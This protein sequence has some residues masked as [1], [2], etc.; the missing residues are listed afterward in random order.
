MKTSN[1][2]KIGMIGVG[3]F[4]GY[5]RGTLRQAGVFQL[6]AAYDR[7]AT[8][9]ET[10]RTEDGARSVESVEALLAIPEIEGIVISTGVDTHA[11]LTIKALDAGKHVLVEKP[12]CGRIEEIQPILDARNKARRVVAMGH[13]H[14]G[15]D[16][17]NQLIQRLLS[18]GS[19][20]TLTCYEENTSHSGGLEIKPGDWRGLR[21]RNPGGMLLQCGVHAFHRLI[22]LF[23]AVQEISAM[24]RYDANPTTQ[25]ADVANVLIR[26]S[27]GVLGTMNAYHVTAYCHEL[28]IFG[29]K[30]TVYIDTHASRAFFQSRKRNEVEHREEITIPAPDPMAAAMN[31]LNF[32]RAVRE[33]TKPDPNLEDGIA[34][35]LPVFAAEKS[36]VEKR[37]VTMSEMKS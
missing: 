34:A 20:G 14:N 31:V 6:V 32:F 8:A 37:T 1:P 33:G 35:V 18:D 10:A 16:A 24:F 29:T 26:H 30:G 11:E 28:R 21:D 2:M 7:N 9:L 25:T 27:N 17:I 19:I 4:G 36:D 3:G 22:Y 23:G 12:L 5:R 13:G 15:S